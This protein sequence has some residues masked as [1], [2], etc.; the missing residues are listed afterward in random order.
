LL[1]LQVLMNENEEE[2]G[3]LQQQEEEGIIQVEI[4]S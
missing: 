3:I 1:F 4:L 2:G